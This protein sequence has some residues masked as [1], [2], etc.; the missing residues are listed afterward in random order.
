MLR[1]GL[2]YADTE[3]EIAQLLLDGVDQSFEIDIPRL[4]LV[5]VGQDQAELI[6]AITKAAVFGAKDLTDAVADD[7]QDLVSALVTL[8]IVDFLEVVDIEIGDGHGFGTA[9]TGAQA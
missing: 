6:S 3:G 2:H 9:L 7:A 4:T 5:A 8:G 1:P